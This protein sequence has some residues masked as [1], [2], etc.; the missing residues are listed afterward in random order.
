[1]NAT[2]APC[3]ISHD[4][5]HNILCASAQLNV[6]ELT[7]IELLIHCKIVVTINV[8]MEAVHNK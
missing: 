3:S 6:T 4:I 2:T 8:S 5:T 1:M 7:K